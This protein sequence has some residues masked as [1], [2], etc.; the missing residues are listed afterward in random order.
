MATSRFSAR[1]AR[2]IHFAHPARA[3]RSKDFVGAE[4][5]PCREWHSE[6]FPHRHFPPQ[7]IEEIQQE[8]HLVLRL[9]RSLGLAAGMSAT[10]RLPSG[11]IETFL[12]PLMPPSFLA[13]HTRGL[14]ATKES[15]FTVYAAAMIWFSRLEKQIVPAAR[16]HRVN[17]AA[18][19]DLPLAAFV[20]K[21]S[22]VNLVCA[23]FVGRIGQPSPVGRKRWRSLVGLRLQENLGLSGAQPGSRRSPS[24]RSTNRH[25]L[26][27]SMSPNA[28]LLSIRREGPRELDV[29]ALRQW[30]RLARPVGTG[31][32]DASRP[33]RGK[34]RIGRPGSKSGTYGRCRKVRRVMASRCRS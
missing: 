25:E 29:L 16:P 12:F 1:V 3:D 8:H 33:L 2:A 26:F 31:Q 4:L 13:D 18:V 24:A 34:R 10:M 5:C 21:G 6:L 15:P 19:R 32:E 11:V 28:S 20:R 27:E 9:L 23:R 7:L 30:L 22:H 17:A 14:S